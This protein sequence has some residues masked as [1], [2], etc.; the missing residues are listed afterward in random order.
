MGSKA[1]VYV[2]QVENTNF[3]KVGFSIRHNKRMS[4]IQG[5]CPLPIILRASLLCPSIES[6]RKTEGI[7]HKYCFAVE[8]DFKGNSP[9]KHLRRMGCTEWFEGVEPIVEYVTQAGGIDH[10]KPTAGASRNRSDVCEW[11][12]ALFNLDK[13]IQP[14]CP[15]LGFMRV[16]NQVA[17]PT[18]KSINGELTYNSGYDEDHVGRWI[19]SH[20]LYWIIKKDEKAC[21]S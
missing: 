10:V 19:S 13:L 15:S 21:V 20:E 16:F 18:H 7:I 3:C 5:S 11:R 8:A 12:R 9:I 2:F 6:A 17:S 4:D 1:T 14:D